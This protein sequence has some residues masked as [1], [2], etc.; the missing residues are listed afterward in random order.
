MEFSCKFD[1]Q[2]TPQQITH[3]FV[4]DILYQ[5][6][7]ELLTSE[8]HTYIGIDVFIKYRNLPFKTIIRNILFSFLQDHFLVQSKGCLECPGV[9]K[10]CLDVSRHDSICLNNVWMCLGNVNV[11][12][13]V[14]RCVHICRHCLDMLPQFLDISFMCLRHI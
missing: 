14:C 7:R 10:K 6:I 4:T 1:T 13:H 12:R 9:C 8:C 3:S 2:I 11:S 5:P